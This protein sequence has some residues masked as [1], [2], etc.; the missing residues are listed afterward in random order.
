MKLRRILISVF[1]ACAVLAQTTA[2]AWSVHAILP[3]KISGA[4]E[5][6][7]H[8]HDGGNGSSQH[9]CIDQCACDDFCPGAGAAVP[10]GVF[11]LDELISTHFDAV[12][13]TPAVPTT[14]ADK[15][16]RPPISNPS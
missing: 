13:I 12:Q 7:M 8:C 5:E 6:M 10:A 14:R 9:C 3:H 1:A 4:Q 16:F 11:S 15:R 2:F